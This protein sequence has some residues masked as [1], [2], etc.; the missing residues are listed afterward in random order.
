MTETIV[1]PDEFAD[2]APPPASIFVPSDFPLARVT[3]TELDAVLAAQGGDDAVDDLYPLTPLQQGILFHALESPRSGMYVEQLGVTLRGLDVDAYARAWQLVI[4]RHTALRTAFVSGLTPEPLQVVQ[5]QATLPVE[6]LDWSGVSADERQARLDAHAEEDLRRGFDVSRAPLAR[7]SLLRTGGDEH[8]VLI[9]FHHLLMDGWSAAL[10]FGEAEAA[11][12]AL[13]DGRQPDF[14]EPRPFRDYVAWL[15]RRDASAA[16]A[17]WRQEMEGV[18][19]S[20]LAVARLRGSEGFGEHEVRLT[21]DEAEAV[22]ALART[23]GLTLNTVFQGALALLVSRWSNSDDVVFG[24]VS[25]GRDGDLP[26]V[27]EI[28]GITI[29]TLPVRARISRGARVLPWLRALQARQMEAREHDH[30]PLHRV[31]QW[32]GVP[33][34]RAL[35]DVLYAFE[36]YPIEGGRDEEGEGDASDVRM[37]ERTN[38]PLTVTIV[39][40]AEPRLR[41]TWDAA[42]LAETDVARM[43]AHLRTL[44]AAMAA[45]G[46]APLATL[47]MLDESERR[48]LVEELNH[49]TR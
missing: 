7:L 3:Q 37:V 25:S 16:E 29:N 23:G 1:A 22:Q 43:A 41:L 4:D 49:T 42:R 26:G 19:P 45:D 38:Y 47:P 9:T 18:R 14:P 2:D 8:R 24:T 46:D 40:G 35:F 36:N 11:Y 34:D 21:R 20:E 33:A 32:A 6:R 48:L 28:V 13:R 30:A 15:L 5:R 27:G 12:Q 44:A 31:Q 17:F 39:P 10:V